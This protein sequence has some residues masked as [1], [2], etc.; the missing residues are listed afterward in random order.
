VKRPFIDS[1]VVMRSRKKEALINLV[2]YVAGV[3]AKIWFSTCRV[4]VINRDVYRQYVLNKNQNMIGAT[5]HRGAIF[6]VYF[7]G[8]VNP[9]FLVSKSDDAEYLARFA[10]R[11]GVTPI[12]GSSS[13]GAAAALHQM[14][15]LLSARG[16]KFAT[17]LD[18]PQG[19]RLKAKPGLIMLAQKTGVPIIPIAWSATMV[20]TFR[21]SWDRTMLPLPFSRV[22]VAFG[23]PILVPGESDK[24]GILLYTEKVQNALNRLT[25]QVDK[26]CGYNG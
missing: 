23:A 18:G 19:P 5:W 7:F 8:P 1:D 25:L 12:R 15:R 3:I 22:R 10:Q 26:A 6:C 14:V 21:K 13:R 16:G 9:H 17:V 2:G 11:M 20:Y 24:N 4:T